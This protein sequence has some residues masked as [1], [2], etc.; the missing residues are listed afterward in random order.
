MI[1]NILVIIT[2]LLNVAMWG[3][4]SKGRG[5]FSSFLNMLCVLVAGGLALAVWEP[6]A[7]MLVPKLPD[8]AWCLGLLVP[9]ALIL[10]VIRQG[11][12][13]LVTKNMDFDDI[14]NFVGG[15]VF[16]LGTGVITS[17]LIVLGISSLRVGPSLLGYQPIAYENGSPVYSGRLWVP[18][19]RWTVGLY[20]KLSVG[21]FENETPLALRMPHADEQMAMMRCSYLIQQEAKVSIARTTVSPADFS[22]KGQHHV[23]ASPR[24]KLTEDTYNVT[25]GKPKPHDP[26]G[27]A[28]G[29][30]RSDRGRRPGTSAP[31]RPR[32]CGPS[33]PGSRSGPPAR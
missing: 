17:A 1:V 23:A 2:L 24:S 28:R 21:A 26:K 5:L 18:T 10:V 22:V 32:R 7:N 15:A 14:T 13:A 12:D 29:R 8:F 20:E 4:R 33:R 11:L 31:P 6:A 19:D 25:D 16:G 3:S 9:F 27:H 30:H